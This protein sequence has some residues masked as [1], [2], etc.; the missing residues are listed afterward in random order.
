MMKKLRSSC[1]YALAAFVILMLLPWIGRGQ[2]TINLDNAANWIQDGTLAFTSYGNHAYSESGVTIQGTNVLRNTTALQDLFPGALGTYSMRIEN[3]AVSKVVI[4]IATGGLAD[5][6]IKVRRWDN[7]PMPNYT[8]KYSIDGGTIWNSLT[9]IDGTL[10]TNSDFFLYSSG[11]INSTNSNIQIEIKN[12]GTT[13]RIM[14]DDFTWTG[15]AGGG[16]I[17]PS[18]T[19]IIQTPST[20]ITSSTTVS[21]SADITDS[22]GTV[23]A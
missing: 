1:S 8:V 12:T 9:N 16:N 22:D 18:I 19:N 5:F 13:E 21:V 17:V 6:S 10:L 20:A 3:T 2:T 4:S 7:N 11:I 15:Y 23:T 14:I